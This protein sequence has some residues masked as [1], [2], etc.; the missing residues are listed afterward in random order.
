MPKLTGLAALMFLCS[1]VWAQGEPGLLHL[2]VVQGE[3]AVY[4][5]GGRATRGIVVQV[6]DEL[7]KPLAGVTVT[8]RLP[9]RGPSGQF[10]EGG[11]SAVVKTEADG[12]AEVWGMQWNNESG[13]FELRITAAKGEARAGTVCPLYLSDA[14]VLRSDNVA[15]GRVATPKVG[16]S[17]KKL[18]IAL[19]LV[20]AASAAIAG[21]AG[22]S[23]GVAGVP[24][25]GVVN[26]PKIGVPTITVTHP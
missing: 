7:G 8:F 19:G 3:G 9:E 13:S 5:M 15:G 21:M 10:R 14:P 16:H 2:R 26:P 12:R 20:A 24:P 18:W 4:A 11:L 17:K 22:R 25:A 23:S 6:A 1:S